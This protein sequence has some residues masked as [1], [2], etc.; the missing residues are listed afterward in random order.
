MDKFLN[1][2]PLEHYEKIVGKSQ[3]KSP[4]L[5][6]GNMALIHLN[7]ITSLLIEMKDELNTQMRQKVEI[8][9]IDYFW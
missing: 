6:I 4:I 1:A 9:F 5:S 2:L 8:A 7:M 3:R